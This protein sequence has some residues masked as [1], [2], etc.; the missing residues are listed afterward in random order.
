[1]NSRRSIQFVVCFLLAMVDLAVYAFVPSSNKFCGGGSDERTT[2]ATQQINKPAFGLLVPSQVPHIHRAVSSRAETGINAT[3]E[4]IGQGGSNTQVGVKKQKYKAQQQRSQQKRPS[5]K[6][7]FPRAG[8]LPDIQWRSISMEHLRAHPLFDPLPEVVQ[9]VECLEDVRYFRQDSWQWDELHEGRCTTSQTSAALGFLEP[10]A[11]Q[12]LNIPKSWRRGGQG[13]YYRLSG[14]PL[15]S[16][17][18][19]QSLLDTDGDNPPQYPPKK[20]KRIWSQRKNGSK[21]PFAARYMVQMTE[22]ERKKRRKRIQN[23]NGG[24]VSPAVRMSWGNAQEATSVLTA[25][26]YFWKQDPNIRIQE[27]G[28][29]G[30]GLASNGTSPTAGSSSLLLGASPDALICYPDGTTEV[31]E[32]KNHCPFYSTRPGQRGGNQKTFFLRQMPFTEPYLP[33]HYVPQMMMEMLCV[34]P[35]CKSAIMVRQTATTGALIVRVGRSDEWLEEMLF[36]LNKFQ[37][38]FVDLG[39]SPPTDFFWDD[40]DL[41]SRYQKFLEHTKEIGSNVEVVAHVPHSDIQRM[42]GTSAAAASLFLDD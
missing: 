14:K 21:L 13:A 16:L 25:L 32:V 41:G 33:L 34:G 3:A 1:M 23:I 18:D 10:K 22:A 20:E 15:R 31:L 36:W 4:A 12:K 26:N 30:A 37:S 11:G 2:K 38:D 28:M 24:S 40:P 7:K 5:K 17:Q 8:N 19:M 42:M 29:C 39:V 27:V 9:N 6:K 35:Q